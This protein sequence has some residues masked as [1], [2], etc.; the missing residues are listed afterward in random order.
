MH[1]VPVIGITMGDPAGIGPEVIVKALAGEN[2]HIFCR[3]L[4]IGDFYAL[5]IALKHAGKRMILREVHEGELPRPNPGTIDVISVS[6]LT[7]ESCAPG[8]PCPEGGKAMVS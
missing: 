6:R 2:L 1:G 4:V 5:E 7:S 8:M 3:P